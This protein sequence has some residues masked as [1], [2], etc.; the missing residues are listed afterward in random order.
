[1]DTLNHQDSTDFHHTSLALGLL[2]KRRSHRQNKIL[3]A[4]EVLEWDLAKAMEHPLSWEVGPSWYLVL[5][6]ILLGH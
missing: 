3:Q 5:L 4:Q 6:Q 1:M 2:D